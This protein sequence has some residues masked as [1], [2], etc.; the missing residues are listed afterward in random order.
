VSALAGTFC[1]HSVLL[2]H[3]YTPEGVNIAQLGYEGDVLL[4]QGSKLEAETKETVRQ[5]EIFNGNEIFESCAVVGD[6]GSLL[7]SDKYGAAIDSHSLVFK[8]GELRLG[9]S[10]S[11]EDYTQHRGGG[12][13]QES[14][15]ALVVYLVDHLPEKELELEK[16]AK[17]VLA[18]PSSQNIERL[19]SSAS[20]ATQQ[21]TLVRILDPT[22]V[23][24]VD[25]TFGG[26][27]FSNTS[28]ER[29]L[30][31]SVL[32][33]LN[34]CR[35]VRVFGIAPLPGLPATYYDKCTS[36]LNQQQEDSQTSRWLALKKYQ[37]AG[38]IEFGEAC[39]LECMENDNTSQDTCSTCRLK[40]GLDPEPL[41][42]AMKA[43]P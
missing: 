10:D 23:Q 6:S 11:T 1:G 36:S 37:E 9:S 12:R 42:T 34:T 40:H 27:I 16:E 13:R 7:L 41:I 22:F 3:P 2:S 30:E 43:C 33:A 29:M 21:Q 8:T 35:V 19:R 15:S 17:I 20:A 4:P 39:I 38:L 24:H 18:L 26:G 31:T 25:A 14:N 32:L 5:S 28:S